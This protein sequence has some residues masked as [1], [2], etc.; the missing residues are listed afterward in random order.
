MAM[1]LKRVVGKGQANKWEL[2][3]VAQAFNPSP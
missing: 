3:T 2:G 1:W